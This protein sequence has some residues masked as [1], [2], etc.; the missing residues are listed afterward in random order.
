MIYV[1]YMRIF[2]KYLCVKLSVINGRE[3][4]MKYLNIK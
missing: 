1:F 4:I 3:N 2:I